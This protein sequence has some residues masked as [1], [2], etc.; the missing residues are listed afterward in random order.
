M[1]REI[2]R[3][4]SSNGCITEQNHKPPAGYV[5]AYRSSADGTNIE[6]FWAPAGGIRNGPPCWIPKKGELDEYH[7]H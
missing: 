4:A 6:D 3:V 5:R 7:I 2:F 1:V